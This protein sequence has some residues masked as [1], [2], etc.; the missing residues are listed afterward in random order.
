MNTKFSNTWTQKKSMTKHDDVVWKVSAVDVN[1][2]IVLTYCVKAFLVLFDCWLNDGTHT[3]H[4]VKLCVYWNHDRFFAPGLFFIS[5]LSICL[6]VVICVAQGQCGG[7]RKNGVWTLGVTV[8][9]S[10]WSKHTTRERIKP[11][12]VIKC[13]HAG[14]D[15]ALW[16]V[17]NVCPS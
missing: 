5:F 4:V 11:L 2:I 3:Q 14:K 9:N 1:V 13:V 15:M 7:E 16:T 12:L 10:L 17:N 8:V 6:T